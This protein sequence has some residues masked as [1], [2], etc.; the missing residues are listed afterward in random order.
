MAAYEHTV[1]IK[2]HYCIADAM[3]ECIAK[4]EEDGTKSDRQQQPRSKVIIP[5]PEDGKVSPDLVMSDSD[6]ANPTRYSFSSTSELG[7][8]DDENDELKWIKLE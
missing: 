1:L 2:Q 5:I 6:M 8:D 7:L 4:L 3:D